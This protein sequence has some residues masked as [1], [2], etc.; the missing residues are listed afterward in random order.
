MSDHDEPAS[1]TR[2][3]AQ[4]G[5]HRSSD[6]N[7]VSTVGHG[8]VTKPPAPKRFIPVP[9]TSLHSLP[10]PRGGLHTS[11][12]TSPPRQ[13]VCPLP[14]MQS[15]SS[16]V[17]RRTGSSNDMCET[18]SLVSFNLRF[19][20][21]SSV[22]ISA[23][24]STVPAGFS[25]SSTPLHWLRVAEDHIIPHSSSTKASSVAVRRNAEYVFE[26]WVEQ[27]VSHTAAMDDAMLSVAAA[28]DEL[29]A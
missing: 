3:C 17:S 5:A 12:Y 13:L 21:M 26:R 1:L 29:Y 19:A 23:S 16:D 25:D 10:D 8:D 28:F 14:L 22:G 18:N 2:T 24:T 7:D 11:R 4:H 9:L 27:K 15:S 20:E 6:A